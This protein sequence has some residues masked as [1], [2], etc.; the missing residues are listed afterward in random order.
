M[1]ENDQQYIITFHQLARLKLDKLMLCATPP[2]MDKRLIKAQYDG[3]NSLIDELKDQLDY[4]EKH[5]GLDKD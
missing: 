4:Y 2:E 3:I 1:I 5:Y